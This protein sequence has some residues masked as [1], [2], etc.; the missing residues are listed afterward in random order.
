MNISSITSRTAMLGIVIG[1]AL[2]T[3]FLVFFDTARSIVAIWNSSET[4]AHGYIILPISLWLIWKRRQTLVTMSPAPCWVAFSLLLICGFGWLL[5]DL[6]D[7]QVVRQYAFVAMLPAVAIAMLGLRISGAMAFPL[8]FLLLAVPFGDVFIEPLINFTADFTVAA[9]QATG[10]PVLRNGSSFEIPSGSWSVVEACSGVRYL[11]S[12]VTLGCLYAYLTYTSRVRQILFVLLSIIVPIVANGLRAYM[13]VM[14]GHLSGM[15]LAVGVDHLIYG[16]LFF[17][18]V[19]FLMFWLGSFWHEDQKAALVISAENQPAETVSPV[20]MT[21][22]FAALAG[23]IV[24]LSIWP[25]YATY[26]ERASYNPETP[27]LNSFTTQWQTILPVIDWRPSFAPAKT[28]FYQFFR[29]EEQVVGLSVLYYRNQI[30]GAGLISSSNKL[31][32]EKDPKWNRAGTS[33]HQE[34]IGSR[35]FVMWESRLQSRSG[36]LLV[37]HWYWIDGQFTA[38]DY[39]GKLLLTKEKMLMHGDDG[40]ALAVFAPYTSN[41]DEARL[42][43]REFLIAN[44]TAL[45]STLVANRKP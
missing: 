15:Q 43:M 9:L 32:Q 38:N 28:E 21:W 35:R 2:L 4:F 18:L 22:F 29:H 33:T 7:V 1:I 17:G 13:I 34:T 37:W 44:I 27:R 10:I 25:L 45:D 3:P 20:S 26:I 11:I 14:I 39:V 16:W 8:F 19:M 40:A 12:S 31:V 23:V 30:R 41:P 6:G 24:S 36:P 5:A 42:A